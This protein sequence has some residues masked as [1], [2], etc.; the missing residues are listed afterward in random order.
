LL[1]GLIPAKAFDQVQDVRVLGASGVIEMKKQ[2]NM[3]ALQNFFVNRGVWVRPFGHLIYLMPP[4][5]IGSEELAILIDTVK[6][7]AQL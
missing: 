7:A 4:Y 2:V 1:Q 3:A 6:E 5:I